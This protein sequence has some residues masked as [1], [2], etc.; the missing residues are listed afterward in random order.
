MKGGENMACGGSQT[1]RLSNNELL[2]AIYEKMGGVI[3]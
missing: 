1:K 2:K 3:E